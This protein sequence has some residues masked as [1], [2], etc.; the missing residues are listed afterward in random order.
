MS[1]TGAPTLSITWPCSS[2]RGV[3]VPLHP[4]PFRACSVPSQLS[5]GHY[6]GQVL[7]QGTHK[8]RAEEQEDPRPNRREGRAQVTPLQP[9]PDEA[10]LLLPKLPQSSLPVM[11][12]PEL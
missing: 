11:T 10:I 4:L 12:Q 8:G 1:R 6:P 5:V 3:Q 7:P 2:L 9:T